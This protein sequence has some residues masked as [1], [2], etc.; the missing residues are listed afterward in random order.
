MV[1]YILLVIGG[2]SSY[3]IILKCTHQYEQLDSEQL[4]IAKRLG[5]GPKHSI[6]FFD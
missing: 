6:Y 1:V 2:A 4:E 5:F 3:S